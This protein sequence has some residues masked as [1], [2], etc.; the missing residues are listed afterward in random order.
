MIVLDGQDIIRPLVFHKPA[1]RL[2]LGMEGVGHDDVAGEI[3]RLEKR[4]D[5]GDL[6]G[7]VGDAD[8]AMVARTA[9][10]K[11]ERR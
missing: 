11:A 4:L 1:G 7:L 8:L 6:V 10:T 5:L 3:E 9:P 2:G